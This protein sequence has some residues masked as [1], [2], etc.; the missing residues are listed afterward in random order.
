[1]D[2]KERDCDLKPGTNVSTNAAVTN[3]QTSL[4]RLFSASIP[5]SVIR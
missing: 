3:T 1:M 4:K 2:S 5:L